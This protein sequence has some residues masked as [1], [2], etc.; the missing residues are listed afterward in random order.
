MGMDR[1][2]FTNLPGSDGDVDGI[3]CYRPTDLPP[4]WGS[5]Q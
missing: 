5:H 4:E 1:A 3:A 2:D